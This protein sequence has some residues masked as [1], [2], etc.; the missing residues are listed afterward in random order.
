MGDNN[1]NALV[2]TGDLGGLLTGGAAY[3]LGEEGIKA[4]EERGAEALAIGEQL[5][6]TA[7]G[8]AEFKPYT[9]TSGLADAF[10]DERGGLDLQLDESE[11]ARQNQYLGQAQ[12][13]FGQLGGNQE[14]KVSDL[15]AQ[16]RAIQTPEEERNRLRM[17]EGLFS[18]GRGGVQNAMFGG[19]NAETFGYEQARQEAM[20][21]AQMAARQQVGT[22]QERLFTQAQGLQTA[23]YNPQR[24]ALDMF[25]AATPSAGYADAARRTGADLYSTGA[26]RGL[27]S[28]IESQK[29]AGELRQIQMQGMLSAGNSLWGDKTFDDLLPEFIKQDNS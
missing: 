20:L 4:A 26:G 19:G 5:G 28:L 18:S 7:S 6:T 11:L 8:M 3:Y 27:E 24:Q 9:V 1:N 16:M 15:Y 13:M 10:T 12:D 21:N 25:G 14:Q 23:G 29:Q 17:Q 22:E 2:S